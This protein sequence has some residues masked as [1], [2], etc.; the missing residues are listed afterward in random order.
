MDAGAMCG[1]FSRVDSGES[2]KRGTIQEAA[3]S[4]S[5][6]RLSLLVPTRSTLSRRRTS[7]DRETMNLPPNPAAWPARWKELYE[8]RAAIV[9]FMGNLSRS[10]AEFRAQADVRKQAAMEKR[11]ER[12]V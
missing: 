4:A 5:R 2:A 3:T 8:E 9:E 1:E 10:T 12:N 7:R 11:E 6:E